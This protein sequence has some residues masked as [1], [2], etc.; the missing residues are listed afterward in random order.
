MLTDAEK[1]AA[2]GTAISRLEYRLDAVAGE[3]KLLRE[4]LER[5]SPV[6][7]PTP[8]VSPKPP[9]PPKWAAPQRDDLNIGMNYSGAPT[10]CETVANGGQEW[11]M[12]RRANGDWRDS[13]GYWRSS[14]GELLTRDPVADAAPRAVTADDYERVAR[15][16]LMDAIV[17][18]TVP[19]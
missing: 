17:R 15:V 4:M 7:T 12:G 2:H 13:S 11:I 16:R 14:T 1:F 10:A 19:E 8:P 5:L 9:E 3:M 6:P 18:D